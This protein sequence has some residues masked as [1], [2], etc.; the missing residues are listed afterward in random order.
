MHCQA[1]IYHVMLPELGHTNN[2]CLAQVCPIAVILLQAGQVPCMQQ[3]CASLPSMGDQTRVQHHPSRRFKHQRSRCSVCGRLNLSS[4]DIAPIALDLSGDSGRLLPLIT[5]CNP[6]LSLSSTAGLLWALTSSARPLTCRLRSHRICVGTALLQ[7][8][9]GCLGSLMSVLGS[10]AG[11][12]FGTGAPGPGGSLPLG[13][14]PLG[15]LP[16]CSLGLAGLCGCPGWSLSLQ[17]GRPINKLLG[18][19]LV[20][21]QGKTSGRHQPAWQHDT[22]QPSLNRYQCQQVYVFICTVCNADNLSGQVPAHHSFISCLK[23]C[24]TVSYARGATECLVHHC[25]VQAVA[26]W[27]AIRSP[28]RSHKAC[29]QEPSIHMNKVAV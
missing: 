3:A 27:R 22:V 29:C 1:L 13:R 28:Q 14:W 4:V 19:I 20:G 26:V 12:W 25:F 7:A 11:R 23:P 2:Q 15:W 16:H 6:W 10:L 8:S 24:C 21:S 9:R 5:V 18:S 17:A